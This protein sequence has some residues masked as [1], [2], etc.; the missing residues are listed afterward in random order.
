MCVLHICYDYLSLGHEEFGPV[1]QHND[2]TPSH[3]QKRV[4][5]CRICGVD[6]SASV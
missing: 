4:M 5:Y 1:W 2:H 6:V 3:P